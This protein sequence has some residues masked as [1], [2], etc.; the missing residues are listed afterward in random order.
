MGLQIHLPT[1]YLKQQKSLKKAE[2]DHELQQY[3]MNYC[4]LRVEEGEKDYEATSQKLA[5][6]T[7]NLEILDHE[8]GRN[9]LWIKDLLH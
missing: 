9:K 8:V 7:S 2:Q 4:V 6:V 5:S 3:L 1:L